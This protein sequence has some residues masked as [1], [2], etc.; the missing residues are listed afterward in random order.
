M[1]SEEIVDIVDENNNVL[2]SIVRS[3]MRKENLR[4]RATFIFVFRDNIDM[5]SSNMESIMKSKIIVQKRTTT[6][7]YCPGKN[8]DHYYNKK[9][10]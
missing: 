3:R 8:M 1:G 5:K 7:D 9:D 4:H 2:E 10:V 6:K